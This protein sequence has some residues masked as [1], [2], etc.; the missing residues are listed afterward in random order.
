M[1]E[2]KNSDFLEELQPTQ[3][4]DEGDGDS[5]NG[6][7][8]MMDTHEELDKGLFFATHGFFIAYKFN[9]F[10]RLISSEPSK[11]LE[12]SPAFP[13]SNFNSLDQLF[14]H[15]STASTPS[16]DIKPSTFLDS[17]PIAEAPCSSINQLVAEKTAPEIIQV[18]SSSS[19]SSTRM[20]NGD[21]KEK[22]SEE[23]QKEIQVK[24]LEVSVFLKIM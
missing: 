2:R 10:A 11:L 23:L 15:N 5:L 6:T 4:S 7:D 13:S 16:E 18:H 8:L 19:A 17:H 12:S 20:P 22:T 9:I 14:G 3:N 1:L 21:V 24:Q